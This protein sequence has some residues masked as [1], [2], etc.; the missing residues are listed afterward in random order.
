M[1]QIFVVFMDRSAT[2]KIRTQIFLV[3]VMDYWWVWSRQSS[4]AKSGVDWIGV[5]SY[6]T[7]V[8]TAFDRIMYTKWQSVRC[9]VNTDRPQLQLH[10][11]QHS[12]GISQLTLLHYWA[13]LNMTTIHL[14]W[15]L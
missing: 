1:V 12:G 7:N 10:R 4:S 8:A 5:L 13:G 9:N 14:S 6:C 2:T 15:C 11:V 3:L